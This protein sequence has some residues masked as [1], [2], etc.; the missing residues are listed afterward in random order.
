MPRPRVPTKLKIIKGTDQPCRVNANEPQPEVEIPDMPQWLNPHAQAEW[1]R[2]SDALFK[3]GLVSVFDMA[4]LAAYC[5]AYGRWQEAEEMLKK[6]GSLIIKTD[7]G[8][9]IQN[10]LLG[11]AN[12]ALREMRRSAVE[13]G[14]SPAARSRVSVNPDNVKENK[15]ANKK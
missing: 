5:Q 10:P 7:K 9:V 12:T 8:N 13:F 15:W 3:Q 1:A 14:M 2:V 11:I 4:V 6:S